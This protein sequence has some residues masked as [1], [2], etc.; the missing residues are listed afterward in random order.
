[1]YYFEYIFDGCS[2]ECIRFSTN[3]GEGREDRGIEGGKRLGP[4]GLKI[5]RLKG[6]IRIGG[7]EKVGWV[8][9]SGGEDGQIGKIRMNRILNFVVYFDIDKE[10]QFRK[11]LYNFS[12]PSTLLVYFI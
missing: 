4:L 12:R 6:E 11:P 7:L 9:R 8:R 5:G 2:R 3:S 1:M 10:F